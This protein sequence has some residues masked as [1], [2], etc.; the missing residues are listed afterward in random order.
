MIQ[1]GR[2]SCP[3]TKSAVSSCGTRQGIS[4]L[5]EVDT[6]A[7]TAGCT[8][9]PPPRSALGEAGAAAASRFLLRGMSNDE[10]TNTGVGAVRA[11][12]VSRR[13]FMAA[14]AVSSCSTRLHAY[15][16]G[17]GGSMQAPYPAASLDCHP[18]WAKNP[19]NHTPKRSLNPAQILE[20]IIG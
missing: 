17:G 10:Q 19:K 5:R 8:P 11:L 4:A 18:A 3:L 1:N 2:V 20:I 15:R 16:R 13:H 12:L 14:A 6:V 9:P 7:A